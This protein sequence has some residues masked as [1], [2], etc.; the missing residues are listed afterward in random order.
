MA[1]VE[2]P[3]FRGGFCGIGFVVRRNDA[4]VTA[5]RLPHSIH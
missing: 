3:L 1:V 4:R 5:A 2:M